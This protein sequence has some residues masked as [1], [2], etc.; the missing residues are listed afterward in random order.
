MINPQ[1]VQEFLDQRRI[2]VIGAS[3][4][5][6][7]FG[8]TIFRAMKDHGYDAIPVH[9][10]ANE[11]AGA[12]C[13]PDISA[14]PGDVDGAIVM[15]NQ[16]IAPDIVDACAGK[17]VRRVWLFKGI[18]SPGALSADAVERC[19]RHGVAVVEGACPL[20]FLEPVGGI[21]RFHRALRH[22]NGSL[23]KAS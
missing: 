15:V 1:A 8:N 3:D 22:L 16:T 20:M 11:V 7:N 4:D 6:K 23:A 5:P 17:G 10:T 14:V 19:A 21:H 18:G 12:T 13:Y 9:P 2:A